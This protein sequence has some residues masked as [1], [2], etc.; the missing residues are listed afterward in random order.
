MKESD[1]NNHLTV[2]K[3]KIKDFLQ[4]IS[5]DTD[6]QSYIDRIFNDFEQK[7]SDFEIKQQFYILQKAKFEDISKRVHSKYKNYR[8]FTTQ[9]FNTLDIAVRVVDKNW[10]I[11]M[12]NQ[13]YAKLT[14]SDLSII[15]NSK[16]QSFACSKN[17]ETEECSIKKAMN[18]Y[19]FRET[20]SELIINGE[21]RFFIHTLKPYYE[22]GNKI[23]GIIESY[24]DITNKKNSEIELEKSKLDLKNILENAVEGIVVLQDGKFVYVNPKMKELTGYEIEEL[25]NKNF[26]DIIYDEDKEVIKENHIK[27]LKG[28]KLENIYT[29]R[30]VKKDNEIR[31]AD[32]NA[33]KIE[34]QEKSAI[35]AFLIDITEK[36]A[37][38]KAAE[39]YFK[40]LNE[41]NQ[42][43]NFQKRELTD[44]NEEMLAFIDEVNNNQIIIQQQNTKLALVNKDITDSINYA[45]HIQNAILPSKT[46]ID[47]LFENFILHFPKDIVSGDFY[48]A[49]KINNYKFFAI[50][51]CTGHG[52]PGSFLTMLCINFLNDITERNEINETSEAL[53]ILRDKIKIVFKESG[54]PDGMD[55]AIC[56]YNTKTYVLQFSGAYIPI[57]IV[58]NNEIIEYKAVRNPIG[59]YELERKFVT[60]YIDIEENDLIYL[61]TDGYHDQFG[62]FSEEP[63][64]FQKRNFKNLLLHFS[65]Y[66][67]EEQKRNLFE[68]LRIWQGDNKQTDDILLMGVKLR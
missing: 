47:S 10:Q 30:F 66:K 57:Y 9:L 1:I 60:E 65:C 33:I 41:I 49:K 55:I 5:E 13:A 61:A 43:L 24:H 22:A 3:E 53:E 64:K 6:K 17:C 32:L 39:K 19:I 54:K 48:Y 42:K 31:F 20:D 44:Y 63:K 59:Y 34:W 15:L 38:E 14:N 4:N 36:N 46:L 52:V 27:R 21:K 35:L 2:L 67:F 11:I 16:C 37:N 29:F 8:N 68:Y 23:G 7:I 18:N 51:D 28:E 12:A 56:A 62:G 26:L 40:E 45:S 50:A 58:K 25:H